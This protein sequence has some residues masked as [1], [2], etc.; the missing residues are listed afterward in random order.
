MTN[1]SVI[2]TPQAEQH[3][4]TAWLTASDRSAI[5]VAAHELELDL[6]RDPINVGES[7]RSSVDRI[8]ILPPLGSSFSVVVDDRTVYVT[9]VWLII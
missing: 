1:Y 4:A 7:R 5:T 8:A 3:L 2:W 9:A 6:Q